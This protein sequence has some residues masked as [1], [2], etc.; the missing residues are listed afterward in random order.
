MGAD[1][2]QERHR[3]YASQQTMEQIG[4]NRVRA[5]RRIHISIRLSPQTP[6]FLQERQAP[7]Y[8]AH[9]TMAPVGPPSITAYPQP[10]MFNRLSSA[11][12]IFSP[13]HLEA[14]SFVPAIRG[15]IGALSIT[16]WRTIMSTR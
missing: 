5:F 7:V 15:T 16:G 1:S 10:V 9:S 8:F 13:E 3:A 11:V 6:A 12:G 4:R 14:G 2:L